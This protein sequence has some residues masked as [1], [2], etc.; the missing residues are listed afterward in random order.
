MRIQFL[1]NTSAAWCTGVNIHN[2][3]RD[4]SKG[5]IDKKGLRL[6]VGARQCPGLKGRRRA[7][8]PPWTIYAF[9]HQSREHEAASWHNGCCSHTLSLISPRILKVKNISV[10]ITYR[11]F[12]L[13]KAIF[14]STERARVKPSLLG[15]MHTSEHQRQLK[16]QGTIDQNHYILTLLLQCF[17]LRKM[18]IWNPFETNPGVFSFFVQII[19]AGKNSAIIHKYG[20]K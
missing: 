3:I 1:I 10:M 12:I 11:L 6:M 19:W 16:C 14:V 13:S 9:I 2:E 18:S 7:V 15:Y 17:R 4:G 8:R 5:R 20:P